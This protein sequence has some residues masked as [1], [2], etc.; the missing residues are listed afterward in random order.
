MCVLV[1]VESS[2]NV[3]SR[4][5]LSVLSRGWLTLLQ[6]SVLLQCAEQ[7]RL[8]SEY[9]DPKETEISD[10]S[11]TEGRKQQTEAQWLQRWRKVDKYVFG[12]EIV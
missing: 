5:V 7:I 12:K 11:E 2:G 1:A 6:K 10:C 3:L 8:Q 4:R 9:S